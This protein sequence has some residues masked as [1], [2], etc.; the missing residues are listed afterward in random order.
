[1][2]NRAKVVYLKLHSPSV[3]ICCQAR[4][5]LLLT[6]GCGADIGAI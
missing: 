4:W 6:T 3:T 2:Y 5:D 1:L